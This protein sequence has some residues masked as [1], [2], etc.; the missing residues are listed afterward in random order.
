MRCKFLSFLLVILICFSNVFVFQ[1]VSY[2][3]GGGKRTDL[4]NWDDWSFSERADFFGSHMA[5]VVFSVCGVILGDVSAFDEAWT[6]YLY[7]REYVINGVVSYEEWLSMHLGVDENDN[8]TIDDELSDVIY[9]SVNFY[10]EEYTGWYE[11]RT[12]D[13][14][15]LSANEFPSQGV[16]NAFIAYCTQNIKGTD[17]TIFARSYLSNQNYIPTSPA[18]SNI[19]YYSK[20]GW[21]MGVDAYITQDWETIYVDLN[22]LNADGYTDFNDGSYNYTYIRYEDS[23]EFQTP[24]VPI[25]DGA[26]TVRVYKSLEDLKSYSVGQRPYYYTSKFKEYNANGDN[27]CII[28]DSQLNGSSLYGDVVNNNIIVEGGNGLTE[29]QLMR[30]IDAILSANNGGGNSGGG[31]VSGNDSGGGDG[32][33]G[34][35]GGLGAIGDV[36]LSI[37]GKLLEYIGKAVQLLSDTVFKVIDLIPQ[38]ITTLIGGL[39]PFLPQEWLTAIELSLVLAVIAG[40]VGIFKK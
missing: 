4:E 38:N 29:D 26:R 1:T 15:I 2:A 14:K 27:S 8:L 3:S 34:L 25:T 30:I 37:L 13:Y 19:E 11:C 35:L 23:T 17:K 16:Y 21:S 39:F 12:I 24:S 10:I 33:G 9:Q 31:S 5:N 18:Y 6:T 7:E 22:R 28:T 36:I 20:E 32:L 40:I